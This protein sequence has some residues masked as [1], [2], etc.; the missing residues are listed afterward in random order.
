[1]KTIAEIN[2]TIR[3]IEAQANSNI[4][5]LKYEIQKLQAQIDSIQAEV[6]KKTQP[7]LNELAEV[8]KIE[9]IKEIVNRALNGELKNP[10]SDKE[11]IEAIR[12][13]GIEVV[14]KNFDT[15]ECLPFDGNKERGY[16]W[17][18]DERWPDEKK[19]IAVLSLSANL[20]VT[21]EYIREFSLLMG[22]DGD[23]RTP[24]C[25]NQEHIVGACCL[26]KNDPGIL[27]ALRENIKK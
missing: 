16:C 12:K 7:L 14:S 19:M 23:D 20:G 3:I 17:C 11:R 24:Y 10:Y 15:I 1:M 9:V 5:L 18:N 21:T 2:E 4:T 22:G 26:V 13:Y 6:N 27:V 25:S 8:E